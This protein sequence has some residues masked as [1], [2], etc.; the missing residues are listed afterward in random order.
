MSTDE[1]NKMAEVVT[2]ISNQTQV[3]TNVMNVYFSKIPNNTYR[4]SVN[5]IR[6]IANDSKLRNVID[7]NTR[8]KYS[9]AYSSY[10]SWHVFPT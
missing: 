9:I 1:L 2:N 7:Q 4:S 10:N 3:P 8:N 5:K 6:N